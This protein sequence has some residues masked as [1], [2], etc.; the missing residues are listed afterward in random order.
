MERKR[1]SD[2]ELF[3]SRVNELKNK[4]REF[5]ADLGRKGAYIT[6]EQRED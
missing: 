6:D 3:M 5:E 4:M 2:V 1:D